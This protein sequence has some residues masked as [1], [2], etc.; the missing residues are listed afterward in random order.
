MPMSIDVS[1][2]RAAAPVFPDACC[3]CDA[4]RPGS[5][6]EA[7]G[8]RTS[9][10]EFLLPWLWFVGPRVR[11]TVPACAGCRPQ[12]LASRRWRTVILVAWLAAALYFVM[13]WIKSFDLPRALAR[14]LG[15]LAV[16]A[17]KAPLVAWWTFR[18]PAFDLTVHKDTVEYEFAS[19]AY[20][21]RFLA[22]NPGARIG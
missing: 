7:K 19:R 8:R 16:L 2:P 13:P 9:G 10:F 3:V 20:A 17:S 4:A 1:L 5:S 21:L 14:P 18:P 11:V 22:C 12:A 15:V 6:F